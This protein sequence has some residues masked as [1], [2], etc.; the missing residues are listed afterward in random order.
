MA[1]NFIDLYFD[2]GTNGYASFKGDSL[3]YDADIR[4]ALGLS[5]TVPVGKT[6]VASG[7]QDCIQKGVIAAVT[8]TYQAKANKIQAAKLPVPIAKMEDVFK[9]G[10]GLVG[11]TYRGK[12][13][14]KVTPVRRRILTY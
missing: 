7:R 12:R 11:K 10:T 4:T 9:S 8:I 13:V 5:T 6:L 3:S 2:V 1:K 14:T